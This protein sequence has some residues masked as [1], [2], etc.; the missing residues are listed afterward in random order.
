MALCIS[1]RGVRT[2]WLNIVRDVVAFCLRG[3]QLPTR[4]VAGKLLQSRTFQLVFRP[5]MSVWMVIKELRLSCMM[6]VKD[7]RATEV[8]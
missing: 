2:L 3:I 6:A 4:L 7:E 1:S 5:C 8:K